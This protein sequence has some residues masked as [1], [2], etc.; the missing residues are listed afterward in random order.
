MTDNSGRALT[1]S[2]RAPAL[3][4][5][6]SEDCGSRWTFF[7]KSWFQFSTLIIGLQTVLLT[8]IVFFREKTHSLETDDEGDS[9][10][11][12]Y[13]PRC[14]HVDTRKYPQIS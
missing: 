6:A 11:Y 13:V 8:K 2:E 12:L 14:V 5:S 3:S 9:C 7:P 4:E 1:L 10:I